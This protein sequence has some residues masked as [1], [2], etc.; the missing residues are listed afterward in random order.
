MKNILYSETMS[1]KNTQI[2]LKQLVIV[3]YPV[4]VFGK[5][6]KKTHL[7]FYIAIICQVIRI[8]EILLT[9]TLG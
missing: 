5:I 8:E 9:Y 1:K 2:P 7:Q 3:S 4:A 6:N